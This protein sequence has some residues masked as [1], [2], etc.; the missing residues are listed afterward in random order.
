MNTWSRLD[1]ALAIA[2]FAAPTFAQTAT[3]TFQVSAN[4]LNTCELQNVNPLAFGNYDTMLAT[5][6]D[7]TATFEFRCNRN[8]AYQIALDNGLHF[9]QAAGFVGSRSMANGGNFLAYNLFRDLGR[10]LPWGSTLGVGGNT[11]NGTAANSGWAVT[12]IYG[13]VPAGQDVPGAAAPG[14]TYTDATVTITV[15]Y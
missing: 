13:R 14:L 11:L 15:N 12:T 10:T 6:L 4:V 8:T 1:L 3:A 9:G 5:A 7:G 2:A